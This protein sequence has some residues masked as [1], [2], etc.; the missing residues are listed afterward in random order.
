MRAWLPAL[1]VLPVV[2][3]ACPALLLS[4]WSIGGRGR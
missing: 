4:D 3:T 1:L 2:L